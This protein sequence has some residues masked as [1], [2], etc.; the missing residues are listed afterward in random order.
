MAFYRESTGNREAWEYSR[1]R[2]EACT[3]V[4]RFKIHSKFSVELGIE[5]TGK[6][7]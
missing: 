7:V 2:E 3:S 4:E 5:Y 1:L 6:A